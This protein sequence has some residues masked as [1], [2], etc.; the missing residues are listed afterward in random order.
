[1]KTYK[2]RIECECD[3]AGPCTGTETR[4]KKLPGEGNLILCRQ[5]FEKEIKAYP[6]GQ[7]WEAAKMY[8][9]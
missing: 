3:G 4:M 9:K 1:M 7:T 8:A 5:Y 6:N 2:T